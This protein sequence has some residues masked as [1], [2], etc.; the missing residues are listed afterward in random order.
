MVC[1]L[2]HQYFIAEVICWGRYRWYM[3]QWG[4]CWNSGPWYVGNQHG[5]LLVPAPSAISVMHQRAQGQSWIH[6]NKYINE[7][8]RSSGFLGSWCGEWREEFGPRLE[9]GQIPAAGNRNV[10]L[11][12]HPEQIL[13]PKP[14][15]ASSAPSRFGADSADR[16]SHN[17]SGRRIRVVKT[18]GSMEVRGTSDLQS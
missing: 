7:A 1:D 17:G 2:D 8:L 4:L 3:A 18:V 5:L 11:P 10:P 6:Q 12:I 13:C 15:R 9:R 14:T 16:C